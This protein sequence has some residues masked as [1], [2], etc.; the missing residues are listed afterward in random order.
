VPRKRIA[1]LWVAA[2]LL[3]VLL[4]LWGAAIRLLPWNVLYSSEMMRGD[5]L[6]LNIE[7]FRKQHG[8]LPNSEKTEEV[9]SLGFEL[10]ASY[11]SIYRPTGEGASYEVEYYVGFDGPRIIYSSNTKQWHCELC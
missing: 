2:L 3:L 4:V 10:L 1:V 9:V 5:E 7:N 8:R 6:V 11:Y